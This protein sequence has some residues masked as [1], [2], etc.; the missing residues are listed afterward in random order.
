MNFVT[1][2]SLMEFKMEKK[3]KI[4]LPLIQEGISWILLKH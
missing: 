4:Y 2:L 3:K 1:W